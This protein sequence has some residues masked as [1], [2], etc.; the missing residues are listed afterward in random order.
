MGVDSKQINFDGSDLIIKLANA[1]TKMI[2][3]L[4]PSELIQLVNCYY[5]NDIR[6]QSLLEILSTEIIRKGKEYDL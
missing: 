6:D 1:I 2:D 5:D 3:K 4:K